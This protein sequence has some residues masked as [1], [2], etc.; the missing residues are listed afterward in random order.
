MKIS[1]GKDL[2]TLEADLSKIE[3]SLVRTIPQKIKS[4]FNNRKNVRRIELSIKQLRTECFGMPPKHCKYKKY[5]LPI[6]RTTEQIKQDF[7]CRKY[8][9]E[10]TFNA[11][12]DKRLDEDTIEHTMLQRFYAENGGDENFVCFYQKGIKIDGYSMQAFKTVYT[13]SKNDKAIFINE[14][15]RKSDNSYCLFGYCTKNFAPQRL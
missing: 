15:F 10:E 7:E 6:P 13:Y 12:F 8:V 4:Y 3:N 5:V 11:Y 1:I 14:Q 2:F 9:D